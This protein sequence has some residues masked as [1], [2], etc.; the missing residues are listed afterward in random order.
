MCAAVQGHAA[1]P[2]CGGFCNALDCIRTLKHMWE[3][4]LITPEAL[5]A[6]LMDA[7]NMIMSSAAFMQS[8]RV[9]DA[10]PGECL[11]CFAAEGVAWCMRANALCSCNAKCNCQRHREA[12][13]HTACVFQSLDQQC[14]Y[15]TPP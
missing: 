12:R 2:G 11:A 8:C 15:I 6:K 13:K 1:G 5:H 9:P 4:G 14:L 3:G 10:A 7:L